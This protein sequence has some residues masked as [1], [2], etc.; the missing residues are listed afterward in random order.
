MT[1]TYE[2]VHRSVLIGHF[3]RKRAK[4]KK[5]KQNAAIYKPPLSTTEDGLHQTTPVA[6]S[7]FKRGTRVGHCGD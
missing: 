7:V 6:S 2:Y 4:K 5:G 1:P 3:F